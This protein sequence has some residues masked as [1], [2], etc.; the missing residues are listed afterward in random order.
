MAR[1]C[2]SEIPPRRCAT[3]NVHGRVASVREEGEMPSVAAATQ[4]DEGASHAMREG[5]AASWRL[6]P[7][8]AARARAV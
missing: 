6:M 7:R 4:E 1:A 8:V 3:H 5:A 2:S